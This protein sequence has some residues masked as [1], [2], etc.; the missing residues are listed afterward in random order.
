M[1]ISKQSI[2]YKYK[3]AICEKYVNFET[4]VLTFKVKRY[5]LLAV[6]NKDC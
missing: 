3:E 5:K 1:S 4:I 6:S 2:E